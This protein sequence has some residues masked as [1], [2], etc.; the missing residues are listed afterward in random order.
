MRMTAN[1][2]THIFEL[3]IPLQAVKELPLKCAKLAEKPGGLIP[4]LNQKAKLEQL[5]GKI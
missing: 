4:E 1:V 2:L 3:M 5:K